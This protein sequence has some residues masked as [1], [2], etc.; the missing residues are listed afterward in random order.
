M[1][2]EQVSRARHRSAN[3]FSASGLFS[4]L[5]SFTELEQLISELRTA[6]ERGDAFEVFAEA[7]LATQP[8]RGAAE[9]WPGNTAPNA[10]LKQLGLPFADMGVDGVYR[11]NDDV[12]TPYQAKFRS[13][14]RK[15]RWRSTPS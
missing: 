1:D 6:Q 12:L 3:H 10:V 14:R 2:S 7:Y 8:I 4:G 5:T 15:L 9:V 13:G 11:T